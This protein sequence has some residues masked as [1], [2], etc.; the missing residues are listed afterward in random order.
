MKIR[1]N[2]TKRY[3]QQ[4]LIRFISSEI[5]PFISY[6]LLFLF[7]RFASLPCKLTV[8]CPFYLI[9]YAELPPLFSMGY[10]LFLK[11]KFGYDS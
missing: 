2:H 6:M 11:L 7:E 10:L 9:Y 5:N 3:G 8:I 1:Q 4:C